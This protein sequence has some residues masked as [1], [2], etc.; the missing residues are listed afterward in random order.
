MRR[1]LAEFVVLGIPTNL[2]FLQAIVEH[3]AFRRGDLSTH[4]IEEHL[5]GWRPESEPIPEAG[6]AALLLHD[7]VGGHPAPPGAAR[8]AAAPSPWETLAGWR[9]LSGGGR[10]GG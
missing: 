4:F 1:A 5:P 6:L 10:G 8:T 7:L 9:H 3:E 2:C